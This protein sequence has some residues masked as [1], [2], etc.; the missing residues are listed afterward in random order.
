MAKRPMHICAA[1][2]Y[3]LKFTVQKVILPF[4]YSYNWNF[5]F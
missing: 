3:V 2:V 5:L 1:T 4:I